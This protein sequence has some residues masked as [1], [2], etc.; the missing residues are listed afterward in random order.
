MPRYETAYPTKVPV[1]A[2]K[3]LYGFVKEGA[4]LERRSEAA[5]AAYQVMGY[6]QSVLLG[7][8]DALHVI[9]DASPAGP[10]EAPTKEQFLSLVEAMAVQPVGDAAPQ[11]AQSKIPLAQIIRYIITVILPLILDDKTQ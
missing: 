7:N 8:P 10:C 6:A 11:I 1:E 2:A 9:G 4:I 5:L 3:D